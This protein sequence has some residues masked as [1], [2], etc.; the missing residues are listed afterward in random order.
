MKKAEAAVVLEEAAEKAIAEAPLYYK[1]PTFASFVRAF[2]AN[3]QNSTAEVRS[4]GSQCVC[5]A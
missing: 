5:V 3:K 2:F 4:L 1:C